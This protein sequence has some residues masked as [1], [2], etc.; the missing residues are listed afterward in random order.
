MKTAIS[1]PDSLFREADIT[2]RQLGLA[3]SQLYA[4]AIKEFIERHNRDNITKKLN[5]L[6][7]DRTNTEDLPEIG[8]ESMREA[9]ED[10]S[11]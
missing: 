4:A 1:L 7:T 10:D 6:Y 2:A 11:W 5:A 3:R 8:L 9:T